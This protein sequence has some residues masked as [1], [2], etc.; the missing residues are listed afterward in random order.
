MMQKSTVGYKTIYPSVLPSSVIMLEFCRWDGMGRDSP[1]RSSSINIIIIIDQPPDCCY[2]SVVFS[3]SS[4]SCP[5]QPITALIAAREVEEAV[6][7]SDFYFFLPFEENSG[8]MQQR[9]QQCLRFISQPRD[10]QGIKGSLLSKGGGN[11]ASVI[12]QTRGDA[13]RWRS[14]P[15]GARS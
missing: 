12:T 11:S 4:S 7:L 5:K 3:S 1:K 15:L 13:K 10:H 9:F 14:S 8:F 2:C 6:P